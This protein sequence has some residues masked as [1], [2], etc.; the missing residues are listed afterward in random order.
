MMPC[1]FWASMAYLGTCTSTP[2]LISRS[3]NQKEKY[4]ASISGL[5]LNCKLYPLICVLVGINVFLGL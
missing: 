2:G 4:V 5:V 3:K 1:V